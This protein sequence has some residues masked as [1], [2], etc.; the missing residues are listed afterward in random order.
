MTLE[1]LKE[2]IFRAVEEN[3]EEIVSIGEWVLA[4]P[5]LG[6]REEET[7][8]FVREKFRGLGMNAEYPLAL[9]G[10]RAVL[11]GRGSEAN[12][13]IIGEMDALNC[14][15]HIH[16]NGR[17]IAHA[18]GHH[19]QIA[20]MLGTAIVLKKSGVMDHLDGNAVFL[21]VPAE[22]FVDLEYRRSLRD[23]GKIRYFSGKQQLIAE[24]A[25]DG[26]DAAMMI[27]AQPNDEQPRLYIRGQNLGFVSKTITFRGK[28]AHGSTPFYGTNALNAAALAIL[29]MH[30]NR[31]TFREEEK[32]RI[33]PIIT[34]GGDV[35][36]SVPD[37]VVMETY[38]RGATFDAIRKG[39]DA[40]A[41]A[42]DGAAQMIGAA[43]ET[44]TVPGYLPL[45][46]DSSLNDLF[47]TIAAEIMPAENI[48]RGEDITGSTDM[49][50]L[51]AILPVIQPSV[52]GFRGNLHSTAFE[53]SSPE[54]YLLPVR[55]MAAAAAEL[56]W[57]G[58]RRAKEIRR[59]FN[60]P[61]TR[62]EYL[63]YLQGD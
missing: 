2:K 54:A 25:F 13:C 17:G 12:I 46:E 34:K 9:T 38:V 47:E 10:T 45:K 40:L 21:A 28:A 5:E 36:N 1:T 6:Y 44:Q 14:A 22:E 55:L 8:A 11:P 20:A 32:I 41:R 48:V 33:H 59:T 30:A 57:D 39:T 62:E 37:E 15:G 53:V 29:G 18:C 27:H 50:D 24:G 4:H 26:M 16:Q 58:A 49:G 19:A 52:G 35:V 7:S 60:P 51:S 61:M 43:A 23:A 56:L 3:A 42:V 63:N 31:E